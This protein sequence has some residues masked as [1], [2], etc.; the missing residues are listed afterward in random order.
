MIS[1]PSANDCIIPYSM[2]LWTIFTKCPA[3]A[4][5]HVRMATFLGQVA[6]ERL[7]AAK[8]SARR[9]P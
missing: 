6:A 2:P 4:R 3:P 5:A 8:A 1:K 9:R 7:D